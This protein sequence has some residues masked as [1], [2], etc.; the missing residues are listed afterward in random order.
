MRPNW[1]LAQ[2]PEAM[3]QHHFKRAAG[4]QYLLETKINIII[5][6]HPIRFA[7][8]SDHR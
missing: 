4:G 5:T 3:N 8:L 7:D 1:S 2:P 6:S